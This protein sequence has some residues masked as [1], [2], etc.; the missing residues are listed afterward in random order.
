MR[1]TDVLVLLQVGH[2]YAYLRLDKSNPVHVLLLDGRAGDEHDEVLVFLKEVARLEQRR[3]LGFA[4]ENV[5]TDLVAA[6]DLFHHD[7]A[8]RVRYIVGRVLLRVSGRDDRHQVVFVLRVVLEAQKRSPIKPN[9]LLLGVQ[10]TRGSQ[11]G[12]P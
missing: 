5:L 2:Q 12:N 6:F 7:G 3:P 8:R 9:M 1:Q 4:G 10:L 11:T